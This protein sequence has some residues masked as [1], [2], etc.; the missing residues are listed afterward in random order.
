MSELLALW[1][2][3]LVCSVVLQIASTLAWIVSP[4]HK[5]D[6]IKHPEEEKLMELIRSSTPNAGQQYVFPYAEPSEMKDEAVVARYKAGP[7][8]LLN[9]WPGQPNMG[10]NIFKTFVFFV[11][12]TFFIAYLTQLALD[13]GEGFSKVFQ[14]AG[15]AGILAYC[16]AP[17]A[18]DIWFAKPR[19]AV[20]MNWID[21][22]IYGLLTGVIFASMWP[23]A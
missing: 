16:F 10:G 17:T 15:T 5:P 1:L 18:N 4:H 13:P 6:F 7:W 11:V 19:R 23:A 3:I 14:I 22:I 8:G 2:P 21:G 20:L 9:V 12:T